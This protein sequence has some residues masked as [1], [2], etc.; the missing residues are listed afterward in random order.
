MVSD[1]PNAKKAPPTEVDGALDYA[2]DGA[3]HGAF[4]GGFAFIL[5]VLNDK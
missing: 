5:N 3:N 4:D 1:V 2:F